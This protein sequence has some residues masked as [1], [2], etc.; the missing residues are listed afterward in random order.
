MIFFTAGDPG[1]GNTK[2]IQRKSIE[3]QPKIHAEL[4][5]ELEHDLRSRTRAQI[6]CKSSELENKKLFNIF[7]RG[8]FYSIRINS[9][10]VFPESGARMTTTKIQTQI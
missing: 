3:Q 4:V 5:H 2:E 8:F 7:D 10:I 6:A 1:T 9:K